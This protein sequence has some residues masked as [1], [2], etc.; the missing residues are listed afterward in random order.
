[1]AHAF[2]TATSYLLRRGVECEP[3]C[4]AVS[5]GAPTDGGDDDSDRGAHSSSAEIVIAVTAGVVL[6]GGI[7]AFFALRHRRWKSRGRQASGAVPKTRSEA[8]FTNPLYDE[9]TPWTT[10]DMSPIYLGA[11]SSSVV[12]EEQNDDRQEPAREVML[13][14]ELYVQS[15]DAN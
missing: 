13:D 6:I 11:A 9:S 3:Y 1:M 14:P 2:P 15:P 5:D 10:T 12:S 8:I 7:F 4:D